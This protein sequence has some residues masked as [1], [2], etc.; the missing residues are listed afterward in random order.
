MT[1]AERAPRRTLAIAATALAVAAT[2]ALPVTKSLQPFSSDDPGSQ[3]VAARHAI[4]RATGSDPYFGLT[5]LVPAPA[6][7]ESSSSRALAARVSAALAADPLVA[8][9]RSYYT[10]RDPALRAR[11]GSATLVIGSLR[12][13]SISAQLSAAR[14]VQAR[15]RPLHGVE[16]GGLAA[17][18]AQGND[19]AQDDLIRAE[20]IAFPLLMLLAL[21]VF[22]G[23][24]AAALPLLIG[25]LTIVGTLAVLRLLSEA[26]SVS[27]YALNI[28]SAL[29]LGLAVDYSL[30][31]VSRYR[32]EVVGG[33]S[34]AVALARTMSTAGRTIVY[35]SLTIAGVMS[36]LLA[37]PQ[38]FLRSIGLG[39]ILVAA[40]AGGSSLLVL[41]A[42]ITLLG[43]RVGR[44]HAPLRGR[45]ALPE[46]GEPR[47][48]GPS[49]WARVSRLVVRRPALVALGAA[50]VM[51]G[52]AAPLLGVRI[53]QVDANVVPA[54]SG[55]RVVEEA[56]ATRFP[57]AAHAPIFVVVRTRGGR[58]ASAAVSAFAARLRALR[59]V[60]AASEPQPLAREGWLIDVAPSSVPLS[61]ASQ[62]LVREIRRE[63]APGTV[64]AGGESAALVDLKHSLPAHMP[65]AL[66][67]LAVA[68]AGAVLVMTGSALLPLLALLAS[69]LTIAATF[70]A[71]VLVFQ[72]G[73]AEGLLGYTSSHA[74][75]ASTLVLIFAMSFGLAT[76]YGIFL[77]S[78]FTELRRQGASTPEAVAA[79]VERTGRIVTAAALLLC[80]ALGSLMSARHALVKEVG[81]GAALAVALDATLVRAL[82]LPAIVRMLGPACW[83]PPGALV[84][85][86]AGR[87]SRGSTAPVPALATV[88][89]VRSV[90]TADALAASVFC[91][92]GDAA[93][94][95]ALSAIVQRSGARDERAIAVAAFEF[96]RD[97]VPYALGPWGVPATVTLALREGMCTNKANLL[98][99]LLRHAGIPAAYGVLR[100]D[101]REY[102]GAIGAPFATRYMS[103]S[104]THVFAAAYLEG[105]WVRCDPSTDADLS[106]R[107][108]HFCRQTVLVRWDGVH[109][110]M[111]FLEPRH[112][113]ADLGLFADIADLLSKPA[114][115]ATPERFALWNDYLAF[116]R[117]EP[118]FASAEAL[119]RA[120]LAREQTDALLSRAA[121]GPREHAGVSRGDPP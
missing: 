117:R 120:Y 64:L 35:S 16:L 38:S 114:R 63:R 113:H 94:D 121:G 9:V 31:I 57:P 104:S 81:F 105:R 89:P 33:G 17:F 84:R 93:I 85:S 37:F 2:V 59:N 95:A 96:V 79:G 27:I 92:H 48:E 54:G 102:F 10:V 45:G 109:D 6:G 5:A 23:L 19:T 76:D 83:L 61:E 71:L 116:I 70:G 119:F 4:E 20:L 36:C 68:T 49:F 30:L 47:A 90:V 32:E 44:S 103:R 73:F 110:S 82:L 97:E 78:R 34:V 62:D 86:L 80:V 75:E 115:G 88:G 77:L 107:T 42:M 26:T 28:T 69:L 106:R 53:T 58:D 60:A 67:I 18:Y 12:A 118:A 72:H 14:R 7:A 65:L 108:S 51:V 111:D 39:G 101:A 40:I 21:W 25:A 91:D 22:R 56:I 98:I 112:V 3:S 50:A 55:A 29:G 74:L 87:R 46:L 15:L 66:A 1:I 100:V 11:D 43:A 52:L 41:P 13:A 99:A 8:G 24:L